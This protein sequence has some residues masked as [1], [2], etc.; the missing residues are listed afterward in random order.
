[1]SYVK[2]YGDEVTE[3]Y[4]LLSILGFNPK[5]GLVEEVSTSPSFS[6]SIQQEKTKGIKYDRFQMMDM[7]LCPYRFFLDY[8][9]EDSPV[10][11]GNFLYQKYYENLIIE[12]VWKRIG[13]K[14][15]SDAAKYLDKIIDQESKKLEPFFG[16]WKTTEIYDLKRRARNYLTREIINKGSGNTVNQYQET[17]M[18]MRRQFGAAK[19]V[20][21]I[22]EI[23]RRNPYSTF[24][25]LSIRRYPQKEYSLYKLP[26]TANQP[27]ADQLRDEAKQYINQVNGTDRA[28]VPSDWCLYCPKR[29]TCM[30]SFLSGDMN[31]S[32]ET[33]GRLRRRT[34]TP[35]EKPFPEFSAIVSKEKDDE[36]TQERQPSKGAFFQQEHQETETDLR[37]AETGESNINSETE[38]TIGIPK[39]GEPLEHSDVINASNQSDMSIFEQ[40]LRSIQ[41]MVAGNSQ[42][43]QVLKQ[44]LSSRRKRQEDTSKLE[45]LLAQEEKKSKDLLARLEETEGQL[46]SSE[47]RNRSLT[48]K[49][50]TQSVL[51]EKRQAL[52]FTV[53]ELAE[54]RKYSAIIVFDTCS[55][56]NC[57][58]L[59]DGVRDGELV[60]VPKEV[61]NELENHKVNHYFDDRKIKAQR[62]ITAIYNYKRRY[63]LIY[64][65]ALMDLIPDAYRADEGEKEE[66]DN[67]I[68]AVALR[69]RRYT[70]IPVVFITDD[71]SLS[72]KAEGE[73]IEV[74]TSQE[75]LAPPEPPIGDSTEAVESKGVEQPTVSKT[76]EEEQ[77]HKQAQD[78]FL[79]QKISTKNLHLEA[80]QISILQNNGIKT[81]ADFLNQTESS[82]SQMKV[83]K[84]IPFTARYL[85]E[86]ESL[87]KII[88]SL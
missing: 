59:L 81:I 70:D 3:P 46:A 40:M 83:K 21:D 19:F 17:H 6:I 10:I 11:E 45:D 82:F 67:K 37:I 64:S 77:R 79:L 69:Y 32:E 47:A 22:S 71:R 51:L 66:N 80:S 49:V 2:Q 34:G 25:S 8:V 15:R 23:E 31:P 88:S 43:I 55:I 85:K 60:V 29:G 26:Q 76:D 73:D 36:P 28:A 5:A 41:E 50:N 44:E 58:N 7:Y 86:Q 14:P 16:F 84:G 48:T 52:E 12:A 75:F 68:L 65:D 9:M 24:E 72:N 87:K 42:E 20:V 30:E 61:N 18:Q 57:S 1:M 56:M 33:N 38:P 63:P 74:W 53:E 78:E 35:R 4:A 39:A 62:A 27:M 54:L 13:G